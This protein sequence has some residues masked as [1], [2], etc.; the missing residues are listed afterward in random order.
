MQLPNMR[1][2]LGYLEIC[3]LQ[4]LFT[5]GVLCSLL[6]LTWS[7]SNIDPDELL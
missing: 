3:Q 2:S 7:T 5:T 4:A 6:F 1:D